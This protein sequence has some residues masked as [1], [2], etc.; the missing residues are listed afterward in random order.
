MRRGGATA[1]GGRGCAAVGAPV[2]VAAGRA[3]LRIDANRA[4]SREDGCR[5]ASSIDPVGIE[6]FEQPWRP[7]LLAIDTELAIDTDKS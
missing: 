6:L 2:A 3:T 1:R 4:Y 7:S 5:F